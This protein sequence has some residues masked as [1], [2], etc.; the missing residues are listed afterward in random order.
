VLQLLLLQ[1]NLVLQESL[2]D[3]HHLVLQESLQQHIHLLLQESPQDNHH[4]VLLHNL[5]LLESLQDN[6][7]LVLLQLVQLQEFPRLDLPQEL[8]LETPSDQ[9]EP[10]FHLFGIP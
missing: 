3:N 8:L 9:R 5:V 6:H 4:L 10:H 1:H 7:H 2:Q